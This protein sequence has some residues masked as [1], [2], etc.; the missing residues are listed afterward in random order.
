[1]KKLKLKTGAGQRIEIAGPTG[2]LVFMAGDVVGP[3]SDELADWLLKEYPD[4]LESVSV[5]P[6]GEE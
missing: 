1:M 5:E 4:K 2:T 6:D 3:F